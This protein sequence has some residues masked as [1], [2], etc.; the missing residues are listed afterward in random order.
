MYRR[1][2]WCTACKTAKTGWC[3]TPGRSPGA[4]STRASSLSWSRAMTKSGSPTLSLFRDS[5]YRAQMY[6]PPHFQEERT[7]V[8]HHLI[9]FHSLAALITM[10]PEGLI[11]NHV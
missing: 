8:L 2:S 11:A 9:R 6:N 1:D 7:D 5:I 3:W 10:G 4:S